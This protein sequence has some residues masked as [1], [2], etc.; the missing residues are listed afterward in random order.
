MLHVTAEEEGAGNEQVRWKGVRKE[1][2]QSRG[3]IVVSVEQGGTR[4]LFLTFINFE[5]HY[6]LSTNRSD[7]DFMRTI[8][9]KKAFIKR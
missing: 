2:K 5:C 8:E 7:N 9:F 4:G 6:L 3:E 1:E